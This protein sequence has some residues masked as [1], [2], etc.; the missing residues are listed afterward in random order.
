MTCRR[1]ERLAAVPNKW[2]VLNPIGTD[3]RYLTKRGHV[4]PGIPGGIMRPPTDTRLFPSFAR[5]ARSRLVGPAGLA[6]AVGLVAVAPE[7]S[8]AVVY[9]QPT[10]AA[11]RSVTP[12]KRR[13]EV[14]DVYER[15]KASVV[16]IHSE[17]TVNAESGD[18][19]GRAP[20]RPQ[21]V[22]GMGTGIVIDPRG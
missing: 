19:F 20:V 14:V 8:G 22:N 16:N 18:P 21:Q 4:R 1:G 6:V 17:R 11:V 3:R 2:G 5:W 9:G 7:Y 10:P 13:D 12:G 15:V